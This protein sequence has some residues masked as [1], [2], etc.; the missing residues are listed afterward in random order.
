[1]K[2]FSDVKK[3]TKKNKINHLASFRDP[4]GFLFYSDDNLYRQITNVYK[5]D[6]DLLLKSGL[7]QELIDKQYLVKHQEVD[8]YKEAK[9]YKIIK[10]EFIPFI[11]YP[12]QWCFSQLKEA[13]LLTLK[14]QKKTLDY[15]MSLKDASAYNIQFLK[16]KAIFI[17]TLSFTKYKENQPWLAYKQFC[18]HFLAPLYLQAKIDIR[19]NKLFI[20]HI[21]GIPLDLANKLLPFKYKINIAGFI[22]L[23]LHNLSQK[24]YNN[25]SLKTK[26][27]NKK[28]KKRDHYALISSLESAII[29]LKL[30]KAKTVWTNYIEDEACPSYS[31][32]AMLNKKELINEFLDNYKIKSLWDFGANN[33]EF[34]KLAANKG[35]FSLA[36]DSDHSV[37][38]KLYR[39]IEGDGIKNILPLVEDLANP[40]PSIGWENTERKA[41]LEN[42]KPDCIFALALVHHLVIAN[43]LPLFKI[44]KFFASHCSFLLIEFIPKEDKQVKRMLGLREDIFIDYNQ[45]N[46]EAEF[47]KRFEI[48]NQ[49][50]IKDSLRTLYIMKVK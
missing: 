41:L 36:L 20:N 47:Q 42:K 2:K 31:P 48:I 6:Y 37:I 34:S 5:E 27:I 22:H 33:G 3:I 8:D 7:Y 4:A 32:K 43:N 46:F 28:F 25:L 45:V 50:T 1:M 44:V 19:L 38:E 10:P 40:S 24:K 11:S 18:E 29:N 23:Y 30:K 26:R 35:I 49:Q 39:D 14:I 15:E 13:A 17:D 16:G 21:D 9:A 12:Y